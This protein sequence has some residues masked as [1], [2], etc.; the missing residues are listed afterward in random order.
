MALISYMSEQENLSGLSDHNR[1]DFI[2]GASVSSLMLMMGGIPLNA[3]DAP[4]KAGEPADTGFSTVGAPISFGVIGLGTWG[5]E[6][7]QTLA[8]LPNAPVVAICDNYKASLN[9]TKEK[10]APNAEAFDDYKKLL[11]SKAVQAVIIATP[12][13]LHRQ[14]V[15]DA[16][17]A[18]KHVYCEVP[19]AHTAEDARAIAKA[20]KE[21]VRVNFQ[22]GLQFRSD[23]QKLYCLNFVHNGAVDQ[24]IS[25]RSQWHKKTSWR[26]ASP[27]PEREKNLNWRLDK[28]LSLGIIGEVGIHQMDLIG[29]FIGKK[30][31][32]VGG[33]GSVIKWDDGRE[34]ADTIQA[35]LQYP[36]KINHFFDGT[37]ANSYD[38]THDVLFGTDAAILMRGDKNWWYKEDDAKQFGWEIYANKEKAGN[39]LGISLSADASKSIQAGKTETSPYEDSTLHH[40]L[41]AF[42]KNSHLVGK[43]VEDFEL[44]FGADAEGMGDYISKI[45]RGRAAGYQDGFNATILAIKAN[46]AIVTGKQIKLTPELFDI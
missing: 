23:P 10:F 18:G 43:G 20:A 5:K 41:K 27:N 17:K 8:L 15:E 6:V 30:P 25:A 9:K 36:G 40:A 42:V 33:F 26:S 1:R 45:P 14:I 34:V 3:A 16:L 7:V 31:L 29:W 22:S 35:I 19:L 39:Y 28:D 24:I 44:T 38:G 4:V 2:K 11:E 46:E 32:S 37:L 12:T 21:A 13:H